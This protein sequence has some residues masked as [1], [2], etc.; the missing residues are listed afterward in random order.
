MAYGT[1]LNVHTTVG[2]DATGRHSSIVV[3]GKEVFYGQGID[4]TAPG[5]SHHG[6]PLQIVDL[7][8]TAIDEETFGEYLDEMRDHYTADKV[9]I[10]LTRKG[11]FAELC[12]SIIF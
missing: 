8:E 7:G 4:T 10:S 3:Y 5:R 2:A 9:G 1:A 12:S 11:A 6:A